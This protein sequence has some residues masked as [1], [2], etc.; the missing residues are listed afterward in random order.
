MEEKLIIGGDFNGH[1]VSNKEEYGETCGGFG[2]GPRN[3]E[4]VTLLEFGAAFDMI[5]GNSFFKKMEE[6]FDHF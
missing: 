3:N 5:I 6:H 4:G 2:Y 1:I